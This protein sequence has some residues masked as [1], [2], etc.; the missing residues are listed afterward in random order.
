MEQNWGQVGSG[1]GS[2]GGP[3]TSPAAEQHRGRCPPGFTSTV[4]FVGKGKSDV[5]MHVRRSENV[6]YGKVAAYSATS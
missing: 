3:K 2:P 4:S 5:F 1:S 6:N